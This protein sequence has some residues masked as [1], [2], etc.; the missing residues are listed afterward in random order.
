MPAMS[1]AISKEQQNIETHTKDGHETSNVAEVGDVIMCGVNKEK[2][3]IKRDKFNKLYQPNGTHIIPEQSPR[4]V[5]RYT[6]P[7]QVNFI[8]PWGES[9]VLKQGDYV[10]KDVDGYYRI[11]KNEYEQTYNKINEDLNRMLK[12]AGIKESPHQTKTPFTLKEY[13]VLNKFIKKTAQSYNMTLGRESIS[14]YGITIEINGRRI[15]ISDVVGRT[16][17]S[18]M[19]KNY[20][21]SGMAEDTTVS[22]SHKG[23]MKECM[24]GFAA[25]I[26]NLI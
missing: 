11:A 21:L 15:H 17:S 3:V 6:Q 24:Y 20:N 2:Y 18:G 12:L 22:Y 9:M 1:Y 16:P 26:F 5:A 23:G 7:E 25:E 8:A 13:E 4:L 14:N 19:D 10:V